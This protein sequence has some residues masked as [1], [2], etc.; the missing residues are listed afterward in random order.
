MTFSKI[1]FQR[2][3]EDTFIMCLLDKEGNTLLTM[4][5]REISVGDYYMAENIHGA[6]MMQ[7]FP[8]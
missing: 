3:D 8:E 2:I 6:V 1:Q 5:P 7:V 4:E